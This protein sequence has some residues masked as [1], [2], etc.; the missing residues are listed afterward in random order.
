MACLP[1]LIIDYPNAKNYASEIFA[2]AVKHEVM[3]EEDQEKY[4]TH[5]EN[6]EIYI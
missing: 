4:N 5:I 6:L 1:D 3:T 2:M